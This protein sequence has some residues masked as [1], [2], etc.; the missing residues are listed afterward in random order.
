MVEV[1]K[2]LGALPADAASCRRAPLASGGERDAPTSADEIA[3][4]FRKLLEQAAPLLVVFDD[5]Q[6]GEQ[7]FLDLVEH[8][9]LLS[10]GAPLMLLCVAR[11]ELGERRPAWPVA[12][13]LGPL[14]PREV[15]ALLPA[16]VPDSLRERIARAAGGNPLFLTEMIAVAA[17]GGDEV[18][19]RRR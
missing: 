2:Q 15:E 7:T 5:I 1:I 4:A 16:T 18:S 12:L 11:P 10:S 19:C 17:E 9:V 14:P 8:V 6:W 3:W 13:K